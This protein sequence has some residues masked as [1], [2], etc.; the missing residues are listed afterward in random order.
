MTLREEI[1]ERIA[2]LDDDALLDILLDLKAL[3][4]R[5]STEFPRDFLDTL[6]REKDN[7]L[8]GEDA[9]RIATEAVKADR[10]SRRR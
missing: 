5:R 2:K 6:S 3:E 1:Q 8:T 10:Q 9:M 4:E 7:G